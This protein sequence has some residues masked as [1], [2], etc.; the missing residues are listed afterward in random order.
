MVSMQKYNKGDL[1][2]INLASNRLPVDIRAHAEKCPSRKR[3]IGDIFYASD[4]EHV[5]YYL[6]HNGKGVD[7]SFHPFRASDLKPYKMKYSTR[8]RKIKNARLAMST[9]RNGG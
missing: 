1:V 6:G 9:T 2:L 5:R 7:M 3:R 8:R 4:S